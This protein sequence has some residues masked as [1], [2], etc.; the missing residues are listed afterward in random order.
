MVNGKGREKAE[1]RKQNQNNGSGVT[2]GGFKNGR[3][4]R[5]KNT[6]A[7]CG[8]DP[9]HSQQNPADAYL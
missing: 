7:D 4:D 8:G 2:G 6:A 9:G 1:F 5:S 3:I